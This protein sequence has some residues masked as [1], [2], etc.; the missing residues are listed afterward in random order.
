MRR[1]GLIQVM[2][3]IWMKMGSCSS[4]IAVSMY[5]HEQEDQC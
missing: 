2:L 3:D 4:K 5:F 1:V